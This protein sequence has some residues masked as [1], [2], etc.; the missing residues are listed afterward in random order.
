MC[1]CGSYHWIKFNE[2][3][4][5]FCLAIPKTK[6][7]PN[8]CVFVRIFQS[9]KDNI[10]SGCEVYWQLKLKHKIFF[11]IILFLISFFTA[12]L[13]VWFSGLRVRVST[14]SV[15]YRTMQWTFLSFIG[16]MLIFPKLCQSGS[17]CRTLKSLNSLHNIYNRGG[18]SR[19][20]VDEEDV[21]WGNPSQVS[22]QCLTLQMLALC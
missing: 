16:T 10:G 7:I 11:S 15:F 8:T 20:F 18:C 4:L 14:D 13:F 1:R 6:T 12:S 22:G 2:W 5:F 17:G 21:C 3:P 9:C 19:K